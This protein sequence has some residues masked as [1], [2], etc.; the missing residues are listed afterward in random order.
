MTPQSV[1][2]ALTLTIEN[3]DASLV[4]EVIS[5]LEEQGHDLAGS[6]DATVRFLFLY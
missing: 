1:P 5:L 6:I 2:E 4:Q 3:G